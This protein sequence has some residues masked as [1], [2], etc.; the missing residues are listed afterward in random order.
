MSIHILLRSHL[1]LITAVALGASVAA[2]GTSRQQTM[3]E[4]VNS[5]LADSRPATFEALQADFEM[6]EQNRV[7]LISPSDFSLA[8]KAF[9]K[10]AAQRSQGKSPYDYAS[11]LRESRQK[12]DLAMRFSREHADAL[13]PLIEARQ[14]AIQAGASKMNMKDLRDLEARYLDLVTNLQK[15]NER[16]TASRRIPDLTRDFQKLT[17]STVKNT[18]L[19]EAAANIELARREGA[20]EFVPNTLRSTELKLK[21]ANEYVEQNQGA[22]D[23]M[24]QLGDEAAFASRR[25]LSL[26]RQTKA[27][28]GLSLEEIN[29]KTEALLNAAGTNIAGKDIRDL[30]FSAQAAALN[31]AVV[32]F[33]RERSQLASQKES[34][35]EGLEES[36]AQ[37]SQLQQ[38]TAEFD[39][40]QKSDMANQ[41][42]EAV[43]QM[44][45]EDEARVY[46]QG[47]TLVINLRKFNFPSGQNEVP[48][49]SYGLL[50]KVQEAIRTF[51]SPSVT[52]E[53]H[54]DS[55]GRPELNKAL[56]E[57]R[58]QAVRAYLLSNKIVP[59]ER[60]SAVGFG[61]EKPLASNQSVEGRATNRRIDVVIKE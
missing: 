15:P 23:M 17:I 19:G 36:E 41:K 58:A 30:N 13:N 28:Q 18:Y 22:G 45:N 48:T 6:A 8:K 37:M 57:E 4:T 31:E 16:R 59:E 39:Q 35:R 1:T 53:G 32:A 38:R 46:S 20:K 12:L 2:C 33:N 29:L 61:S 26:N 5:P 21:R 24:S 49:Q 44:F 14:A 11:D 51:E 60:I 55:T 7:H 3:L 9:D 40:L 43:R 25:L 10:A 56:S 27:L 54:T 42:F 52:V 34:L 50:Q 47:D